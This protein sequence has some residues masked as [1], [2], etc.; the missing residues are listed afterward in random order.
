M[1][2]G[3]SKDEVDCTF[4]VVAIHP[5]LLGEHT[6]LGKVYLEDKF[7]A[8]TEDFILL[9][10]QIPWK[11]DVI[12]LLHQLF[13]EMNKNTDNPLRLLAQVNTR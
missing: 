7:G 5:S 13:N 6:H 1:H 2:Y 4:L 8:A 3:F 12:N 9:S 10:P 11:N